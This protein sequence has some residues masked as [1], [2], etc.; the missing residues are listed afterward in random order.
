[1]GVQLDLVR[2]DRRDLPIGTRGVVIGRG[3][4]CDIVIDATKVSR[5]HARIYNDATG[6]WAEDLGSTNGTSVNG[7]RVDGEPAALSNGDRIRVGDAEM[8][9]LRGE[10]TT[11]GAPPDDQQQRRPQPARPTSVELALKPLTIGRDRANVLALDDPNVSRFHA[12][13][14]PRQRG[15]V[16]RDLS[17]RNGTRV[18]G[19]T[20]SRVLLAP[21][22]QI[23]IGAYRFT[24]TGSGLDP[25]DDCSKL[26]LESCGVTVSV[27]S[28]VLLTP[29]SLTIEPGEL[30]AII[31]ESGAGKTTL[32]KALA[33][34]TRP[35]GGQVL[36]NGEPVETRL[37]DIGYVP[38]DDIVHRLLT[39]REAL[40][41]AARLRLPPDTSAAEVERGVDRVMVELGLQDR[42][43]VRVDRL[44]G[45][46]ASGS[47]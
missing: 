17:S 1:M 11:F 43:D 12:V 10:S 37:T 41:Y 40:R 26:R 14:E 34:I 24:F 25:V 22:D 38:Q 20:V 47:A 31:G 29:T 44:S 46:S 16:L 2:H 23:A 45:G 5:H 9:V 30:V 6:C 42:A 21:G 28:S 35:T 27:G 32:L 13:I 19:R 3:S 33:G 18:N 15:V 36:A 8:M 4:D 7:R 39:V